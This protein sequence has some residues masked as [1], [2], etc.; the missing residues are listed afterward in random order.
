[1]RRPHPVEAWHRDA[2]LQDPARLRLDR[3][4]FLAEVK[5]ALAPVLGAGEPFST[6]HEWRYGTPL[7]RRPHS[8]PALDSATIEIILPHY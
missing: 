2:L 6:K 7:G 3:R 1:V 4:R 8:S 5:A